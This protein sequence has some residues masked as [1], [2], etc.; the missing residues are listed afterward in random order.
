MDTRTFGTTRSRIWQDVTDEQYEKQR[1]SFTGEYPREAAGLII[2][3]GR[4]ISAVAKE[5]NLGEQTL[6]TGEERTIPP[7]PGR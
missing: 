7:R 6:G 1:R 5:L 3:T 4:N 2:D